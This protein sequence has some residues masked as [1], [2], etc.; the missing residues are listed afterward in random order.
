MCFKIELCKV[1]Y[2]EVNYTCHPLFSGIYLLGV[3]EGSQ[4]PYQIFLGLI[5][6]ISILEPL[7]PPKC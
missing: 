5:K 4:C 2:F 6:S 7:G 1:I 3:Q